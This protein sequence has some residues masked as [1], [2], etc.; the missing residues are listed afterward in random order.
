MSVRAVLSW[1]PSERLL[2]RAGVVL[3]L[4]TAVLLGFR[5]GE[6]S[7]RVRAPGQPPTYVF[8]ECYQAFTA[9]RYVRGDPNAWNP[10]ATEV[11]ILAFDRRDATPHTRYE[12]VHPP[13]AKLVMAAFIAGL[14]FEAVSYRLGSVLFGLL[15][16]VGCWRLAARLRG[17]AFGL[18]VATLLALDGMFFVLARTAMNDIYVAACVPA[19]MYAFYR[20]WQDDARRARW[21]LASGAAFGLGV[22]MKWSAGPLM[23]GCFVLAAGRIAYDVLAGRLERTTA[24][25]HVCAWLAGFLFLPAVIYLAS[26]LPYFLAGHGFD[27]FTS[28]HAQIWGYHQGLVAE[29]SYGSRWYTWPL[30]LRP[31]WFY[32]DYAGRSV[33]LIYNLG[34]P[35]I[36]WCFLPSL[37]WVAIRW[38]RHREPQDALILVGFCGVWLPWAFVDRVAFIQYL[39]PAVPFGIMAIVTVLHDLV[40]WLPRAARLLAVFYIAACA[41]A[42]GFFYPILSGL[43]VPRVLAATD[44]WFWLASW[45]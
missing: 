2:R 38:L 37:A 1:V 5:L 20:Y 13:G 40:C 8:D 43:P 14:G 21:L 23:L 36:W 44:H 42:F 4:C 27:D 10:W 30:M 31:V 15:M 3:V 35:L 16:L 26:Y 18:A 12:W 32:A 39:L 34:N 7:P 24:V 41:A 25:R 29:H 19:A 22:A 6:P 33:R 45:R 9:G 28:L 17:E 11:E